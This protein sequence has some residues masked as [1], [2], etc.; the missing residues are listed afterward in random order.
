MKK[1]LQ[2]RAERKVA[3]MIVG[4]GAAMIASTVVERA[5]TAGWR[6][7]TSKEPPSK[8]ESPHR[9]GWNEALA[10][11]AA[12]ALAIGLSQVLAKRGAALGWQHATGEYPPT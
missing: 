10:W 9:S 5:L 1:K 4:A 12:S 2:R 11:T 8:P 6:K 7:A 3:W